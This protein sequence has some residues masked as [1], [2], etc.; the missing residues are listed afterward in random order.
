MRTKLTCA[1]GLAIGT[2]LKWAG[3]EKGKLTK[4]EG[5]AVRRPGQKASAPDTGASHR[6]QPH[7]SARSKPRWSNESIKAGRGARRGS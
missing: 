4:A 1:P 6:S 2:G 5:V 3:Q 7:D